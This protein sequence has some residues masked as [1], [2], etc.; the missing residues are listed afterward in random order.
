MRCL[1]ILFVFITSCVYYINKS[2]L[3]GDDYYDNCVKNYEY[4]AYENCQSQ[5]TVIEIETCI[6]KIIYDLCGR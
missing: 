5:K 6:K 2:E 4:Y 1:I 3:G